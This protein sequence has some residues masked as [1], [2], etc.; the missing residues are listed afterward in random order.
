MDKKGQRVQGNCGMPTTSPNRQL[1]VASVRYGKG[2]RNQ[3]R[4]WQVEV[5][6]GAKY[7]KVSFLRSSVPGEVTVPTFMSYKLAEWMTKPNCGCGEKAEY[8]IIDAAQIGTPEYCSYVCEGCL[9]KA[10]E[11]VSDAS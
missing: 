1:L 11:K 8:Q 6:R 9:K 7:S 2:N 4:A 10:E 5:R 3:V